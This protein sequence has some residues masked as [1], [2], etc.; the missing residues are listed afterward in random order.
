MSS[1]TRWDLFRKLDN[2]QKRLSTIFGR[3]PVKKDGEKQEALTVAEWAPFVDI[4]GDEKSVLIKVE[5][6]RVKK[7]E[8]KVGIQ[9]D[10][11]TISGERKYKKEE[12]DKKFHRFERAY[13]NFAGSY[14][15]P[16][17]SDRE[18]VSAEFKDG[19]LKVRLPKTDKV[20]PKQVEVKVG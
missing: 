1:I 19:I 2:L 14:T 13:G 5:L 20:K 7:E 12:K 11:L 17:D 6:P 3:A 18:K 15:I 8:I 10:V 4:V 9:D 16:E